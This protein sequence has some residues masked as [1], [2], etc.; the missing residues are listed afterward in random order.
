MDLKLKS[1]STEGN[2]GKL[3]FLSLRIITQESI[4]LVF[5]QLFPPRRHKYIKQYV[6]KH[7]KKKN[8]EEY[9]REGFPAGR[10]LYSRTILFT[11]LIHSGNFG[12]LGL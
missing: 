6:W 1:R 9:Q 3:L 10:I 8:P 4:W 12:E 11:A 7:H 5:N 2:S